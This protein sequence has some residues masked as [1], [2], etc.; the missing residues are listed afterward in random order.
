MLNPH[1]QHPFQ[2]LFNRQ[3]Y[4]KDMSEEN[5]ERFWDEV[6]GN[7]IVPTVDEVGRMFQLWQKQITLDE[8]CL[9]P[10]HMVDSDE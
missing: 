3:E 9:H 6:F 4:A 10:C 2:P 8:S 1:S 7:E 5:N